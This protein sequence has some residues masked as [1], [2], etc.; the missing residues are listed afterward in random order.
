MHYVASGHSN[1]IPAS[2][3]D[4]HSLNTSISGRIVEVVGDVVYLKPLIV[5]SETKVPEVEV[6]LQSHVL[7]VAPDWLYK[8]RR[9]VPKL[10]TVEETEIIRNLG[11]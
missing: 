9:L 5:A 7:E 1:K 3:S 2:R 10:Q 11:T 8:K 6:R 4:N